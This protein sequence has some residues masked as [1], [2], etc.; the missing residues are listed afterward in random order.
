MEHFKFK[1]DWTV[2]FRFEAFEGF[3]SRRGAYTSLSS[4]ERSDGVVSLTID[5]DVS[6]E[7]DPKAEQIEAINFL[8]D[9]PNLIKDTLRRGL[10]DIYEEL[11]VRYDFEEEED[12]QRRFPTIHELSDYDSVFG[13][14]N[15]YI[16]L[17]SK[18]GVA[19]VGLECGCSWDEEHGLGFLL[20]KDK[21]IKVGAADIAFNWDA[22]KDNGTLDAVLKELKVKKTPKKYQAHPKYGKL[23]PT[24][25]IENDYYIINLIRGGFLDLFKLAYEDGDVNPNGKRDLV[26]KTY[27]EES[28]ASGSIGIS[29]FLLDKGAKLGA[30]LQHAVGKVDLVKLLVKYGAKI[31]SE[32]VNGNTILDETVNQ[33]LYQFII[34]NHSVDRQELAMTEIKSLRIFIADLVGMGASVR[35]SKYLEGIEKLTEG[36]QEEIVSFLN[37]LVESRQPKNENPP[38]LKSEQPVSD[39]GRQV[40]NLRWWEFWKR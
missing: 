17:A 35:I 9:N 23:K 27:L 3:Q 36:Q 10:D 38:K 20:H 16:Q 24:Q 25:V 19:Y 15:V 7:P 34:L 31:N 18:E 32:N 28:V 40:E 13:V 26:S 6:D 22:Y 12:G 37:T 1:G 30:A 14:G 4:G 8:I 33:L 29:K 2:D 5:D 39:S 21:L 11:K